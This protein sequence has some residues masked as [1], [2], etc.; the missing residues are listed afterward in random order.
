MKAKSFALQTLA[1]ESMSTTLNYED[2][3]ETPEP[4]HEKPDVWITPTVLDITSLSSN[5]RAWTPP[6]HCSTINLPMFQFEIRHMTFDVNTQTWLASIAV[7][8]SV[9]TQSLVKGITYLV[10]TTP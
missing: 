6:P 9:N 10:R 2:T 8:G 3:F 5:K 1:P 7:S 4:V